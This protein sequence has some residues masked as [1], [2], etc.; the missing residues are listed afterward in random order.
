MQMGVVTLSKKINVLLSPSAVALRFVSVI[1][2][3]I[4]NATIWPLALLPIRNNRMM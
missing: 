3:T 1:S 2:D 4:V